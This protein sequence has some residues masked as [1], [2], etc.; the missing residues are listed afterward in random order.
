M[1]DPVPADPGPSIPQAGRDQGPDQ[2]PT[3]SDPVAARTRPDTHA[4][5]WSGALAV[6]LLALGIGL[7]WQRQ[8]HTQTALSKVQARLAALESRQASSPPTAPEVSALAR[9][10]AALAA[11]IRAI[12]DVSPGTAPPAPQP[13]HAPAQKSAARAQLAKLKSSLTDQAHQLSLLAQH[14]AALDDRVAALTAQRAAGTTAAAT[15]LAALHRAL[16]REIKARAA[17]AAEL[18][19]VAAQAGNTA[20]LARLAAARSA[21]AAGLPLGPIPGAPPALARYATTP[22]PTEA[23]LRLSFASAARAALAASRPSLSGESWLERLW[24]RAAGLVTVR[25]GAQVILG[26]P[27]AGPLAAAKL[28]LDAG[29]LAGAVAALAPLDPPAARAMSGWRDQ[30]QALLAARASLSAME[31]GG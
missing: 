6:L 7:L 28:R 18:H 2:P 20:R 27:A 5:F 8:V 13:P 19:A 10:V 22:P 25:R 15:D 14:L 9:K 29:D 26:N 21:L 30:A 1:T 11:R 16:S 12:A 24:L 3:P 17:L 23:A 4:R 31:H